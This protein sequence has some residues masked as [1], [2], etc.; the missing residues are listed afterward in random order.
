MPEKLSPRQRW[1]LDTQT[2]A[3]AELVGDRREFTL[4]DLGC[5]FGHAAEHIVRAW[6]AAAV[7]GVDAHAETL[8][9][10]RARRRDCYSRLIEADVLGWLASAP[11]ADVILAAELIEHLEAEEGA[12][13]VKLCLDRAKLGLV[14]TSP[15]G[16]APQG[17]IYDNPWQVHRSGWTVSGLEALDLRLFDLRTAGIGCA[18]MI[19]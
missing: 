9:A 3:V 12:R 19:G 13:L 16:F 7:T 17:A 14:V 8:A 4:L 15:I 10:C 11:R 6:P 18:V 1:R 5:E 2:R